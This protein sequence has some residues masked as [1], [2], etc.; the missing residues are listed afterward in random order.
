MFGKTVVRNLVIK[1]KDFDLSQSKKH[2]DV[3]D[4]NR[5]DLLKNL[6]NQ[7]YLKLLF[8]D[9]PLPW[10]LIERIAFLLDVYYLVNL[11]I[12]HR[13][14]SSDWIFSPEIRNYYSAR[15]MFYLFFNLDLRDPFS[16]C[17]GVKIFSGIEKSLKPEL[18]EQ[19]LHVSLALKTFYKQRKLKIHEITPQANLRLA[20]VSTLQLVKYFWRKLL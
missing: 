16:Q 11:D 14:I 1:F 4:Y 5:E 10:D 17:F 2:F 6:K 12:L 8:I 13:R 18:F 9:Q 7:K 20:S 3:V 15:I 19:P